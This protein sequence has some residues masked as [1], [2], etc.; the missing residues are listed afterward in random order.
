MHVS[1]HTC[2]HIIPYGMVHTISYLPYHM[3]HIIT[4]FEPQNL[5]ALIDSLG[6]IFNYFHF[7]SSH[8]HKQTLV[9]VESSFTTI[10]FGLSVK[11]FS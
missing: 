7:C 5:R 2:V 8:I 10:I 9:L 4:Y 1:F 3:V 6:T 11:N